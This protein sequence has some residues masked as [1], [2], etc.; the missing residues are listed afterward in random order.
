MQSI[1]DRGDTIKTARV[2]NQSSGS[3]LYSLELVQLVCREAIKET[4]AIVQF[5]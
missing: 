5:R 4:I 2:A 1:Q 3:I